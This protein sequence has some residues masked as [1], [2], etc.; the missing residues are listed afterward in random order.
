MALFTVWTCGMVQAVPRWWSQGADPVIGSGTPDNHAAA[1]IG[2][3]KW[4]AK[5]ALEALRTVVPDLADDIEADL[6][7]T[8]KPIPSWSAPTP[9]SDLAKA[10]F[11]P[12]LVG[13]LKAISA[14]FY[15]H[16]H[17]FAPD[18][19]DGQLTLNETFHSGSYFPWTTT[20]ADDDNY[21]AVNLGQLK[22]VFS[23]AFGADYETGYVSDGIPD[24]W[25]SGVVHA[26]G[27][28]TWTNINQINNSNAILAGT[29]SPAG[30]PPM[31]LAIHATAQVDD[32]IA[33]LSASA[34]L[35][36][37]TTQN[38]A[39]NIYVRST[40]FWANN[41]VQQLT[42]IS[43]ANTTGA[44]NGNWH[45]RGGTAITPRHIIMTSHLNFFIQN[46]SDVRFVTA[47]NTV[48]TRTVL[49][50]RPLPSSDLRVAVLD[51]DLPTSI[52]PCFV[53]PADFED[54]LPSAL[55][56]GY[57]LNPGIPCL[58]LDQEEKGLVNDFMR[59]WPNNVGCGTPTI[60]TR[61]AFYE[62][63]IPNDSGNPNFM[64]IN[65]KLVL[66]FPISTGGGGGGNAVWLYLS[67]INS[68]IALV[69]EDAGVSTDYTVTEADLSSFPKF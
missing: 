27:G 10:Q 22:A 23:L 61:L 52:T 47:D 51:S 64:I 17:D 1:N 44:A 16:L 43:P 25:E 31:T 68:T 32:R 38:H 48:V 53:P 62:D 37:Y 24:L 65:N 30:P 50:S 59:T 33:G 39:S 45:L 69:N 18:W 36:L 5:S 63:L 19:L 2:Q 8:G 12:L 67:G 34:A 54:Y 57:Q 11:A 9:G 58:V 56:T 3:A 29:G 28:V 26:A 55:A 60:S 35:P 6:V 41:I 42:C 14:P 66:L 49:Y 46:G 7:G 20:A 13:Q 40:G 21:G 4:M 15:E